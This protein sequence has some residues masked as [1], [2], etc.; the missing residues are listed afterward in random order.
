MQK[1]ILALCAATTLAGCASYDYGSY[2]ISG[3]TYDA[4]AFTA[5]ADGRNTCNGVI[6]AY[7]R[8]AADFRP[9]GE[10]RVVVYTF[11]VVEGAPARYVPVAGPFMGGIEGWTEMLVLNCGRNDLVATAQFGEA[12]DLS[13]RLLASAR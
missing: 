5:L 13:N 11:N 4:S 9:D 3:R 12:V 10:R 1:T 7:G 2:G 8:P 6:S